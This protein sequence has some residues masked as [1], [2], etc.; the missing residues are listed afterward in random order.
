MFARISAVQQMMGASRF[1]HAVRT[2]VTAKCEEL[3]ADEGLDGRGVVAALSVACR[4]KVESEGDERLAASR[5]GR[6][7]HVAAR[8]KLEDRL[9]LCAVK[10][11]AQIA[12]VAEEKVEQ[13]LRGAGAGPRR[14]AIG[15]RVSG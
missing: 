4:E 12:H 2:E 6:E 5:G 14:N 10:L 7:D 13:L 15:E 8:H 9:L 11:E 3:L 1:T